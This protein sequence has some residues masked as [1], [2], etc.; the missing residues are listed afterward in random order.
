MAGSKQKNNKTTT[1]K[2]TQSNRKPK[3]KNKGG[4]KGKYHK[5]ITKEGMILI[6]SWARDG[7]SNEQIAKNIGINPD[8]LYTWIKRFP[9]ID[10]SLKKGKE[11]VD[12]EVENA[13]LKRAL[14]YEYEEVKKEYENGKLVRVNKTIKRE[15]P[16]TTA[17]IF[18]L[19]NR[20]RQTG[21]WQNTRTNNVNVN[22]ET[23]EILKSVGK[24]LVEAEI[25]LNNQIDTLD[26]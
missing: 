10:E 13:L 23:N 1:I 18:W 22:T 3:K 2:K 19:I 20:S 14:G 12:F 4:R 24:Q 15:A 11:V 21:K 5:W 9:E 25:N 17:Q 26:E 7:L 8:T 16:S 6:R